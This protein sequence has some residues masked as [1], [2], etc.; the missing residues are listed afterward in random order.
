MMKAAA[1]NSICRNQSCNSKYEAFVWSLPLPL[2]VSECKFD[3]LHICSVTTSAL[4]ICLAA[5]CG[6]SQI[7]IGATGCWELSILPV[8][9]CSPGEVVSSRLMP[10]LGNAAVTACCGLKPHEH[11]NI[12]TSCKEE[13]AHADKVG[14]SNDTMQACDAVQTMQSTGPSCCCSR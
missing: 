4:G 12:S 6:C 2:Q 3:H 14:A 9:N 13:L 10:V 11:Q 5:R 7:R 1:C 8:Q